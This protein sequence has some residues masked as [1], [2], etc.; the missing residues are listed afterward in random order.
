[1]APPG[2]AKDLAERVPVGRGAA[3]EEVAA[4]ICALVRPDMGYVTGANIV[5]DGGMSNVFALHG[6]GGYSSY[7]TPDTV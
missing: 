6:V 4:V 1:M 3:P 7:S 5:C 2:S